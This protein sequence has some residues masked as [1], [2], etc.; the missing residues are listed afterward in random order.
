VYTSPGYPVLKPVVSVAVISVMTILI[1]LQ[2]LGLLYLTWY[3]Y[4]VPSWTD[5]LDAMA[6]AHI[7]ARLGQ[8]NLLLAGVSGDREKDA[9]ELQSVDG[10]LGVVN[11]EEGHH[12]SDTELGHHD[13]DTELGLRDSDTELGYRD[14]DTELQHLS[15]ASLEIDRQS[16]EDVGIRGPKGR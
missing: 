14:S 4:H 13:S 15:R 10:L 16:T 9:R 6:V 12:D 7:G 1:G 8:H 2:L 3:I 5:S 11:V